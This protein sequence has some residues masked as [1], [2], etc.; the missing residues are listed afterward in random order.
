MLF[1]DLIT[2][3]QRD[4]KVIS[5]LEEEI[6]R[7]SHQD[8]SHISELT[9]SLDMS[10]PT[11]SIGIFYIFKAVEMKTKREK[12]NPDELVK[13]ISYVES[14]ILTYINNNSSSIPCCIV[15]GYVL[16]ALCSWPAL[17]NNL[18]NIIAANLNSLNNST[19]ISLQIF[20]S[21][22]SEI[23]CSVEIDNKRR[24]ELKK[25]V[26]NIFSTD[27]FN[28]LIN[29]D[30]TPGNNSIYSKRT[31]L[32]IYKELI[33]ISPKHINMA[34][35][36]TISPEQP[37]EAMEFF[38]EHGAAN[39]STDVFYNLLQFLPSDINFIEM[40]FNKPVFDQRVL[41]YMYE[42]IGNPDTLQVSM[43]YWDRLFTA[44]AQRDTANDMSNL[45]IAPFV[46]SVLG[47]I[48]TTFDLCDEDE[49]SDL[50]PTI[51]GLLM[52]LG[53]T[54]PQQTIE[55]FTETDNNRNATAPSIDP[56][57]PTSALCKIVKERPDL[58]PNYQF[59]SIYLNAYK[60]YLL[61]DPSCI[62]Y[63]SMMDYT[64]KDQVKL[65]VNIIEKYTYKPEDL[66]SYYKVVEQKTVVPTDSSVGII[67]ELLA[68]IDHKLNRQATLSFNSPSDAIRF[69]YYLKTNPDFYN[70]YS[71]K[72]LEYFSKNPPF[73]RA[74]SIIN[75][76]YLDPTVYQN[77]L[78]HIYQSIDPN[79][80]AAFP[81]DHMGCFNTDILM[82]IKNN[83]EIVSSF[84]EVECKLFISLYDTLTNHREYYTSLKTLIQVIENNISST[85]TLVNNLVDLLY[86][87][88]NVVVTKVANIMISKFGDHSSN[89]VLQALDA[90][91]AVYNL[92]YCYNL[93]SLI[94]SQAS[95]AT[96]LTY[97][98]GR[99]GNSGD[100]SGTNNS[101]STIT[102]SAEVFSTIL[103]IDLDKCVKV[104]N[105]I[106]N[107]DRKGATGIVRNLIKEFKGKAINKL[108]EKEKV[109]EIY[110]SR[111]V[112]RGNVSGAEDMPDLR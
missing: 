72:Y 57:F 93:P 63:L 56:R 2:Q 38:I 51:F 55:F 94:T 22:L 16:L 26:S 5:Q 58:L 103:S 92:S 15:D 64:E 76:L 9:N 14:I 86:I 73:D 112:S 23:N 25:A 32:L 7:I 59:S 70:K 48:F 111:K 39:I 71:G 67:Y 74:Y 106:K 95:V 84:V 17:M 4:P 75:R 62:Q 8:I 37:S 77:I 43:Q 80:P 40:F 19:N 82:N 104:K 45:N 88:Y 101:N 100:L 89:G 13:I 105:Q 50:D 108:Y 18:L 65:A 29:I 3:L 66:E 91:K 36:Y 30:N 69:F 31:L 109:K 83:S 97:I 98:L 60:I 12:L 33:K 61:K 24:G 34:H 42:A 99:Y 6:T 21:L 68:A 102:D 41:K 11:Y 90:K 27:I 49:K 107:M 1:L 44:A 28:T 46:K 35:V 96:A 87:D 20:H 10:S 81:L 79:K 85:P 78:Q 47:Q 110:E 53:K 52:V 54:Q